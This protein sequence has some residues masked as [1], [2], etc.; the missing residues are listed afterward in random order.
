MK[1]VVAVHRRTHLKASSAQK[2]S[3]T[4]PIVWPDLIPLHTLRMQAVTVLAS[5][6]TFLQIHI[7]DRQYYGLR[8]YNIIYP[9]PILYIT[10]DNK[11]I[12]SLNAVSNI[13]ILKS[14]LINT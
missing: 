4:L 13:Y 3:A 2:L 7:C 1:S 5:G 9:K 11:I 10:K 8:T 14:L 12:V 6:Y